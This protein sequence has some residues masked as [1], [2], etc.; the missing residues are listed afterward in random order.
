MKK[1]RIAIVMFSNV[2]KVNSAYEN[3]VSAFYQY[4][5]IHGYDFHFNH[6][7]YDTE[8]QIFYM[9]LNSVIETLINALKMKKYDWVL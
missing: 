1:E 3:A 8:R 9:K 4:S 6:N 5:Q 7:R 2:I